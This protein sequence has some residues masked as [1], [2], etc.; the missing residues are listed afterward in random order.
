M[1]SSIEDLKASISKHG[2]LVPANRF[3]IIFTP[4]Q[5][6]LINL[7]PT[8]LI[9]SL[10]SGSF[11]AK[12]LINDPR[13]I[14]LLCKSASLPGQ[15]IATLDYQAHK[16]TRKMPNAATQEDLSTVFYVTSDMYI[17]TMFDG[18]LDAIFDRENY[19]VGFKDEFSTD[20]TIQQ[21]NKENRP[22]Y[23]VR[24]RNA[25]P[26]SV[27]GLGLDHS[28]ENTMQELTVSWSYDKWVP[29]NAITSTLGGG[30]RAIQNLIS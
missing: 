17:K 24:L 22:V 11:S 13:D 20:V 7:N 19:H 23:G 9:G 18:W 5:I 30:L 29:E 2:G 10:I 21:L 1:A 14:T 26:T 8:N 16:E 25:F 27:G 3:N 28:S 6:S 12:S 4:P 15:Q